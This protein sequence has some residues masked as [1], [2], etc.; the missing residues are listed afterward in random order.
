MSIHIATKNG[1]RVAAITP[2]GCSGRTLYCASREQ[3]KLH[4]LDNYYTAERRQHVDPLTAY[5]RMCAFG[6]D[7]DR[8]TARVAAALN[9]DG[10][11]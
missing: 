4:A 10:D 8:M 5:D 11:A 3:H 6:D 7:Y 1:E 2:L 9:D